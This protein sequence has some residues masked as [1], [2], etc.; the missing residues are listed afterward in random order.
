MSNK[1]TKNLKNRKKALFTTFDE[2]LFLDAK[3]ILFK[4]SMSIQQYFTFI[5]HKLV[6]EDENSLKLLEDAKKNK[7]LVNKTLLKT[8]K[9]LLKNTG[10][11]YLYDMIELERNK[12]NEKDI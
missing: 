8:N 3:K 7:I 1:K 2:D 6:L 9:K 5:L 4:N 11:D 12:D 10:T